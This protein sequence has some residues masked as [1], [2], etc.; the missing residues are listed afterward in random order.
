MKTVLSV[1][2]V[3]VVASWIVVCLMLYASWASDVTPTVPNFHAGYAIIPGHPHPWKPEI[4]SMLTTDFFE[5]GTE[6]SDDAIG[7]ILDGRRDEKSRALLGAW[8]ALQE[9]ERRRDAGR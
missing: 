7:Y 9:Y 1:I 5:S 8:N 4:V 3:V 6:Y 2:T